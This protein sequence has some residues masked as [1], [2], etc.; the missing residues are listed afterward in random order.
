MHL[1]WV[2]IN[3]FLGAAP[4]C[5]D[6]TYVK[7]CICIN[8]MLNRRFISAAQ[9][10][11]FH[12]TVSSCLADMCVWSQH[13]YKAVF[14]VF[15][16]LSPTRWSVQMMVYYFVCITH[17]F[18]FF[19]LSTTLITGHLQKCFYFLR[20]TTWLSPGD[21]AIMRPCANYKSW[22]NKIISMSRWCRITFRH[23]HT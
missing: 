15:I 13:F 10:P 1:R 4:T 18:S 2:W 22:Q 12:T 5:K 16:L 7:H 20:Y 14:Q 11:P 3:C 6:I 21:W 23:L 17:Q 19:I 9:H 8:C